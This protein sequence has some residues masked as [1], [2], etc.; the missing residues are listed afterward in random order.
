MNISPPHIF[1]DTCSLFL[2]ELRGRWWLLWKLA[3]AN[4][5]TIRTVVYTC[6]LTSRQVSVPALYFLM[7]PDEYE[8]DDDYS[9]KILFHIRYS[10]VQ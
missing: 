10:P 4:I 1:T 8:E 9:V 6:A 7:T 3:I 5:W 2:D